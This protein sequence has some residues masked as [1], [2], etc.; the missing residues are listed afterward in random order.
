MK[1]TYL[2]FFFLLSHA[3]VR[4]QSFGFVLDEDKKEVEIPF[5]IYNNFM[6]V[7]VVINK[8]FPL[9][10]IFDTGAEHTILNKSILVGPLGLNY[11]R[12]IKILGADLNTPIM[13]FVST[14]VHIKVG[15]A[16][17]PT[18]DILVL[19]NDY[20]KIDEY[21]GMEVHGIVGADLFR[22]LVIRIDYRRNLIHLQRAKDF[23]PPRK[24]KWKKVNATIERNKPY[25][26]SQAKI[27][28]KMVDAK[29]LIDTGASLSLLLH[30]NTSPDIQLP[31]TY[32]RGSIGKG[33]GGFL[34]GFLG[35]LRRL[36]F[37][38]F[39]FNNVITNYQDISD[40]LTM[41]SIS[42][43]NGIFGSALLQRFDII[44]N[45]P[46]EKIYMQ[47]HRRYNKDFKYDKSG[48]EL[49]VTGKK[50]RTIT[51]YNVIEQSPGSEVGLQ[52]GDEIISVN[53]L[54]ARLLGLK[55]LS[56]RFTKKAGKRIKI[57]IKR[58][59]EKMT[60]IFKLR[61]LI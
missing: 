50:L 30:T 34:E 58:N 28:D 27:N 38:D 57:K 59:G 2:L 52:K 60:F 13:A 33:L 36:E 5:E 42:Y 41:K 45:Y 3:L 7:K 35:R 17:A 24:K 6:V 9:K 39:Y 51:I 48:L 56:K 25:L 43:R 18:Q 49:I 20:F 32:I 29:L 23:K 15:N 46:E 53:G 10:F 16:K 22:N 26:F 8:S 1:K 55:G 61:D 4:A 14:K 11:D 40:S 21:V 12:T 31:E 44:I 37:G 54:S 19:A 47:P